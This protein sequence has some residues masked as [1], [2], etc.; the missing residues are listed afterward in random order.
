MTRYTDYPSY[1]KFILPN[2]HNE[3]KMIMM[4]II[5]ALRLEGTLGDVISDKDQHLIQYVYESIMANPEKKEAVL[6]IIENYRNL[7]IRK[8]GES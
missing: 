2:I 4:N 5:T 1:L 6:S 3:D 7:S 8:A